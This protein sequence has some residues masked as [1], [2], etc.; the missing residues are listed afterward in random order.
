M[1]FNINEQ[2]NVSQQDSMA[3]VLTMKVFFW[4]HYAGVNGSI[5]C[6]C[7]FTSGRNPVLSTSLFAFILL[8]NNC[9]VYFRLVC[10]SLSVNTKQ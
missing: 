10:S 2:M 1:L 7:R 8:L 4:D 9:V 5:M 3:A 6:S